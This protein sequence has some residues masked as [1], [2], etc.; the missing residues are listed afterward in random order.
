[1][2]EI[3]QQASQGLQVGPTAISFNAP[4]MSTDSGVSFSF[5]YLSHLRSMQLCMTWFKYL[6]TWRLDQ[7]WWLDLIRIFRACVPC[8]S[9]Y[10]HCI[11]WQLLSLFI[12]FTILYKV[13]IHLLVSS[14]LIWVISQQIELSGLIFVWA[15]M[16][17]AFSLIGIR[18]TVWSRTFGFG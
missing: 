18:F 8:N 17:A 10:T 5:G 16:S 6:F 12:L 14:A 1:M 2:I 9:I 3:K 4:K 13:T 11:G 15:S 7:G